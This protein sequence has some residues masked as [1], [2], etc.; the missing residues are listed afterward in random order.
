MH[1]AFRLAAFLTAALALAPAFAQDAGGPLESRLA[2]RKV[3]VTDGRENLVDATNAKPGDLIE[4]TATYRNNGKAPIRN[5]EATLPIPTDTEFVAGSARPAGA[6]ASTDGKSFAA[7][8]LKR[9]ARRPDGKEVEEAIPLRDYRALRWYT[10]ELAGD[11]TV[12]FA[13]RVR[14]VDDRSATPEPPGKGSGK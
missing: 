5:L 7:L 8:P 10:G 4:Y 6:R 13:A 11:K 1:L 3:V 14:V 9:K 12:S 2:A